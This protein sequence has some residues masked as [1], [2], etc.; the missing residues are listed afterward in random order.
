M[1]RAYRLT[2]AG[3]ARL[4]ATA[5]DP[6]TIPAGFI[7]GTS[8]ADGTLDGAALIAGSVPGTSIADGT[9]DGAALIAG[10]VPGT[11]LADGTL[12]GADLIAGSV[13]A[14]ALANGAALAALI[15]AGLGA[16]ASAA[17]D[18]AAPTA[19]LAA[20]PDNDRA[21]LIVAIV[22]A[23]LTGASEFDVGALLNIPALATAGDIFVGA[24]ILTATD[25]LN[26][27][28]TVG[29]TGAVAVTVIA[30]PA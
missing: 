23:D 18:D 20:D 10:S 17:H 24:G 9:L 16:S 30:L 7:P 19:L 13:P 1:S 4:A 28:P 22:T 26:V 2:K 29:T 12:D 21:V 5:I 15:T 25:P 11:A 14:S 27:T 3:R 6:T 8:I